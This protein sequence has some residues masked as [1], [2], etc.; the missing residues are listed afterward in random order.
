[1]TDEAIIDAEEFLTMLGSLVRHLSADVVAE[2]LFP[3]LDV[4]SG[5]YRRFVELSIAGDVHI[6]NA[7]VVHARCQS[8]DT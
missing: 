3:S 5:V 8:K 4:A 6:W 2:Q 1:M 7:R